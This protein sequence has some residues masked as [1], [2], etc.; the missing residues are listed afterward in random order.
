MPFW[1]GEPT[2]PEDQNEEEIDEKLRNKLEKI[3]ENERKR[4]RKFLILPTQE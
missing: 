2:T 4:L 1:V 3:K